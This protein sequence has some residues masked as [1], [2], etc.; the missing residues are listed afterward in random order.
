VVPRSIRRS[1]TKSALHGDPKMTVTKIE[2]KLIESVFHTL[3]GRMT[4]RR[5][6]IMSETSIII[7]SSWVRPPSSWV[8][9]ECK[10][11]VWGRCQTQ[12]YSCLLKM[13]WNGSSYLLS[14]LK[15]TRQMIRPVVI[16]GAEGVYSTR[17]WSDQWSSMELKVYTVQDNDQTCGYQWSWRCAPYKTM[18]R[19]V[20]IN[21]AEGVHRTRQWSDLC[22]SMELKPCPWWYGHIERG[23]RTTAQ[24]E[25][26]M[27][28]CMDNEAEA[29]KRMVD[30]VQ[31]D[32]R[33]LKVIVNIIDERA[34]WKRW[35]VWLT[36]HQRDSQPERER[37]IELMTFSNSFS[38][39]SV[40]DFCVF[41]FDNWFKF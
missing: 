40:I 10:K 17:Q 20:V 8:V 3:H 36:S 21:G 5:H 15:C 28:K 33:Q 12:K 13:E 16:N 14:G 31:K 26:W 4:D 6:V 23:G 18:I 35:T 24:D 9:C 27:K 39:Y 11:M 32:I 30:V 37:F 34:E 25:L 41:C 1:S 29:D 22:L 2:T 38:L 7:M 19:P